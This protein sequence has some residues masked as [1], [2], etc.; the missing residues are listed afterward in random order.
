MPVP[1]DLRFAVPVLL[2]SARIL[3]VVVVP[4]LRV[5]SGIEWVFVQGRVLE[6]RD[7]DLC[8]SVDRRV[9]VWLSSGV[10]ECFDPVAPRSMC[11]SV[12]TQMW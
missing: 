3:S 12:G 5:A 8:C 4:W 2:P 7:V 9:F 1:L 10:R 11:R 6:L